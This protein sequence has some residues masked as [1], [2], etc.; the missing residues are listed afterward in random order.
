MSSLTRRGTGT[1][2]LCPSL[3]VHCR[4]MHGETGEWT[5]G[6]SVKLQF[7]FDKQSLFKYK[8]GIYM[9]IRYTF[10]LKMQWG[11]WLQLEVK[12]EIAKCISNRRPLGQSAYLIH[13]A[14][15]EIRI[16]TTFNPLLSPHT[17]PKA[18]ALNKYKV[19]SSWQWLYMN[20]TH[21]N[22]CS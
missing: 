15:T 2:V 19:Q 8:T 16:F 17:I 18:H 21:F 7:V 12:F 5:G 13:L 10:T 14:L 11:K 20:L 6:K 22:L 1:F 4:E 3:I 9:S